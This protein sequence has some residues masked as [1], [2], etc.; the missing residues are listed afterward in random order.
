MN[1]MLTQTAS[2][3]HLDHCLAETMGK[4]NPWHKSSLPKHPLRRTPRETCA[5]VFEPSSPERWRCSTLP[6]YMK[7]FWTSTVVFCFVLVHLIHSISS[8]IGMCVF[9][10]P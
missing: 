10:S 4:S 9:I 8:I 5:Y 7:Y 3:S 2:S 6:S 1:P